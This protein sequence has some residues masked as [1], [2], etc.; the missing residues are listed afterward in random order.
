MDYVA[1]RNGGR[2]TTIVHI[3]V[4]ATDGIAGNWDNGSLITGPLILSTSVLRHLSTS[5]AFPLRK[6]M[7]AAFWQVTEEQSNECEYPVSDSVRFRPEQI[8]ADTDPGPEHF[9]P[10]RMNTTPQ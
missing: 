6:C 9:R 5:E 4:D 3:T 2:L 8:S 7:C 1:V 10:D